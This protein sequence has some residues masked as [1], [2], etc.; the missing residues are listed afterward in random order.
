MGEF[1]RFNRMLGLDVIP[2]VIRNIEFHTAVPHTWLAGL[3]K[4]TACDSLIRTE[5]NVLVHK[6]DLLIGASVVVVIDDAINK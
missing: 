2:A 6:E 5:R 3:A 1:N 4:S